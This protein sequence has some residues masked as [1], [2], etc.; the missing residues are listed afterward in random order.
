MSEVKVTAARVTSCRV[1][2]GT[3]NAPLEPVLSVIN[4]LL[5]G[6]T[7]VT[8]RCTC[9]EYQIA[10]GLCEL[11]LVSHDWNG[12]SHVYRAGRYYNDKLRAL[13]DQLVKVRDT[14]TDPPELAGSMSFDWNTKA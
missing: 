2:L 4:N 12:Q 13:K 11:D 10:V 3:L 9:N 6:N 1:D 8:T 7:I 5:D 14:L